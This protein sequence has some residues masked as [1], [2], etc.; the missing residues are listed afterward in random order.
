M[1][2]GGTH[3]AFKRIGVDIVISRDRD[4]KEVA[5][6]EGLKVHHIPT[7]DVIFDRRVSALFRGRR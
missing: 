3:R 5:K 2:E 6:R 1:K 4:F 7:Q